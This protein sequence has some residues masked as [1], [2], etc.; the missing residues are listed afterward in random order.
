MSMRKPARGREMWLLAVSND[1][2][3][4]HVGK[5]LRRSGD[6]TLAVSTAHEAWHLLAHAAR[7][8]SGVMVSMHLE[9]GSGLE[10]ARDLREDYPGLRIVLTSRSGE[11]DVEFPLLVEPFS[12]EEI[13][14]ALME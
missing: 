2:S 8:V 14:S 13:R 12:E 11:E 5:A 10:L 3:H 9:P 4:E 1:Q 7:H 6:R